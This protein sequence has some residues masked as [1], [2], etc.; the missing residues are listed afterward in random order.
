MDERPQHR[1]AP[2]NPARRRSLGGDLQRLADCFEEDGALGVVV[3]DASGL[4][5]I[6][7]Q[8]GGEALHRAM[9]NLGDMIQG[10]IGDSCSAVRMRSTS[11]SATS[12]ACAAT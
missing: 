6:E 10:M 2:A 12:T 1:S 3:V 9:G 5:P 11:S 4:A 8:Y 7:P